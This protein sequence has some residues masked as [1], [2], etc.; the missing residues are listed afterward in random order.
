MLCSGGQFPTVIDPEDQNLRYKASGE[1]RTK[2]QRIRLSAATWNYTASKFLRLTKLYMEPFVVVSAVWSLE[3]L[4]YDTQLEVGN[5]DRLEQYLR[6]DYTRTLEE[7]GGANWSIRNRME[8]LYGPSGR[9]TSR[10]TIDSFI[11]AKLHQTPKIYDR[12]SFNSQQWL[13]Y[14]WSPKKATDAIIVSVR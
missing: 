10:D 9:N 12:I 3:K 2:H 8:E 14:I 13:R 1:C 5:L 7:E 11:A 4:K 6:E